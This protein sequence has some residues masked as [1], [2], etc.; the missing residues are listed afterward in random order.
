[1]KFREWIKL[2]E[3]RYSGLW[4]QWKEK[5]P[6]VPDYVLRQMYM[7]HVSP[8]MTQSLQQ[9]SPQLNSQSPPQNGM[10]TA[11][12]F[13][14]PPNPAAATA[15][16]IP[17]AGDQQS[18]LSP[19]LPS[20]V[21]NQTNML[22]GINW[23]KKPEVVT[24]SPMSFD[25]QTI[26]TFLK[27]GFGYHTFNRVRDDANRTEKQRKLANERKE[28]EN[29]PI[30]MIDLGN[31]QYRLMEGFHR[32]ASYLLQG[33]DPQEIEF[34]KQGRM[35]MLNLGKWNPISIKAYVGKSAAQNNSPA[36]PYI[37]GQATI[38]NNSLTT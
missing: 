22:S 33:A 27:W 21:I 15:A 36:N 7:N 18:N 35:D 24:V 4:K 31:G 16:Y 34:L 20:Q 8:E 9:L 30:I 14:D 19:N 32:T 11:Q 13:S 23:S 26:N 1:M 6:G 2:D 28:G 25:Q 3:I 37:S 17:H 12:Y 10:Q 5:N 29:E 38:G